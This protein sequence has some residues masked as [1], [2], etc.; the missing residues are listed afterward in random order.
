MIRPVDPAHCSARGINHST[1][2]ASELRTPR[3]PHTAMFPPVPATVNVAQLV[4]R[5]EAWPDG[6]SRVGESSALEKL[7]NGQFIEL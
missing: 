4:P 1:R 7:S 3:G 6:T 2:S 5:E